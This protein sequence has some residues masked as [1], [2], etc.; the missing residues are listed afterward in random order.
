[1]SGEHSEDDPSADRGGNRSQRPES[2]AFREFIAADWAP[3]ASTVSTAAGPDEVAAY[4]AA[5]RRRLSEQFPGERLVLPAGGLKVRS[6]DT[7]YRFR[8]HSA[9]A[10]MTGLGTDE[11][12]DAVLVLHPQPA[13]AGE[14]ATEHEAVLYFRPLASRESE[15]FWADARY[16]EFWVGARPTLAELET[17]LGLPCRHIDELADAVGKDAGEVTVRVVPGADEAVSALVE[18]IRVQNG[19]TSDS[20]HGADAVL[21]E[22]LSELR[23]TKDEWEI[24]QLRAAVAA[25]VAGF[26]QIVRALPR[27]AG[28]PRGERVIEGA[29]AAVARAEGNG[30][31]YET[32]AA[33]GNNATTLHWIRNDGPVRAGELV[34]VD[35]GVEADSLYTADITRTLP[36]SGEFSGVQRRVYQAVL[37]AADA[38]FA[39]ARPGVRFREIHSTAMGVLAARLEEWGLLPVGAEAALAPRG[40][41]HRRWMPHGT[42][43]HLGLDVHDC[44]QARREMY[45]DAELAPGM[46]FTIEPGL[47]FKEDDRAI[48]AEYR[49][50]GVRIEDDVLVTGDGV[51]NLSG[52]LPRRPDDVEAWMASL[53]RG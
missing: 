45:L 20:E 39:V 35:A 24:G 26:E 18:R 23:L 22:S 5:R 46:V 48:P 37:D 28:H 49:G 43:H 21:A 8:P 32:I 4:A 13:E 36:V 3:P 50:I 16:G 31:G 41:Q 17:R 38:A 9:F 11:E 2:A 42:S 33:A 27:A 15:E 7:D 34:L 44:A 51:V 12:P 1:M 40:Q 29:F 19:V 10:H 52:A 53:R 14:P 47:Y 25:S 30:T 6:N